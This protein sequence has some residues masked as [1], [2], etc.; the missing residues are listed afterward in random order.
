MD[1]LMNE[2]RSTPPVRR[3][4]K[5]RPT[6]QRLLHKYWPTIRFALLVLI[7]ISL[8]VLIISAIINGLA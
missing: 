6:W 4:R 3:R 2:D 1:E 5:R 7:M 8:V